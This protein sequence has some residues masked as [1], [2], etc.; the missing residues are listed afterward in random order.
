MK[1]PKLLMTPL[2]LGT[3]KERSYVRWRINWPRK[4][5]DTIDG[6][7]PREGCHGLLAAPEC[8]E[9]TLLLEGGKIIRQWQNSVHWQETD[10]E[11][12]PSSGR[13]G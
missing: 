5:N 12:Q 11:G 2:V 7:G 10:W 4:M 1:S 8:K 13:Y 3:G 6:L 9:R